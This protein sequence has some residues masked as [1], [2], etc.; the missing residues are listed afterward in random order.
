MRSLLVALVILLAPALRAQE[1]NC[2]VSVDYRALSGNEYQ[3]LGELQ[4]E[5]E[6]YL[7]NRS[8]TDEIFLDRERIDCSVQVTFTR[9]I[10]LSSFE[11]RIVVGASRPIYGTGQRTQLFLI[12]D[13]DW[14][15][16]SYNRGQGLI[17]SPNRFDPFVSIFD[18]YANLILGYD[19]DSFSEL[20]GQPYFERARAISELA[21][22]VNAEGW[23]VVG[24]ERTRGALI[25]QLLD[26]RYEPLRRAYFQ[27]H[28]GVLDH[29]TI[30]H[31]QAWEDAMAV[32][33]SLNELYNEFNARRYATDVFFTAKYQELAALLADYPN[34]AEAYELLVEM[35]TPHQATYDSIVQ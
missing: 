29:F 6:R 8:W 26:S 21:R 20:G 13:D 15:P 2:T 1:L 18:F 10:T 9:A 27:Y 14:G 12:Q 34:R 33:Q 19:F 23:Y 11:A 17:F 28:F 31:E 5:I 7:N 22:S 16:F 3:Y 32:L 4:E 25:T 35:D 30:R 24:D